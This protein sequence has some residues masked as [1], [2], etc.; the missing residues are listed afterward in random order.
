MFWR[1]NCPPGASSRSDHFF[2]SFGVLSGFMLHFLGGRGKREVRFH[3][4][5]VARLL[6][7]LLLLV[8]AIVAFHSARLRAQRNAAQATIARLNY[9]GG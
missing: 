3:V 4:F 5:T 8:L 1:A 9:D 6:S 2:F 7:P